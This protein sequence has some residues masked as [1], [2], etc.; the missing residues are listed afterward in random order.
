[1]ED[2]IGRKSELDTLESLFSSRRFEFLLMHGRR[3][4]GKTY[5]LTHFAQKHP[6]NTVFFTADK[7]SQ[8][9]NVHNFCE[10]LDRVLHAGEYLHTLTSW[11]Q[12]YSFLRDR[13]I[14]ERLVIIIDE[15]TYLLNND[16]S[17]DSQ[18]QN[19]IDR[20]LK[21]KNIFLI[22][23]GSEVSTIENLFGDSRKPLYGRKTAELKLKP[24]TYLEARSFF[25][26]YSEEDALKTYAILGG[27]PYYLKLFDS[28]KP[29]KDNIIK[30][31]FSPTGVLYN[32]P[33]A[34]LRMELVEITFY[35]N[36]LLA[37]QAGS[38]TLNEIATKIQSESAKTSKYLHTLINLGFVQ[39]ETPCGEKETRRNSLYMI[40]DNYFAFYFSFIYR[41]RNM[42]NGLIS[43]DAFFQK[44]CTKDKMNHFIG[45]RFE[46]ICTEYLKNQFYLGCM[47]FQA[48]YLGR[49]WGNNPVE[50]RQEEIDI[51]AID[52]ANALFCE[53]KY[54]DQ[55]FDNKELDDLIASSHCVKRKNNYFCIFSRHGVTKSV[56]DRIT[57]DKRFILVTIDDLYQS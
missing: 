12:V 44:M 20:I 30:H 47:P 27:I 28:A 8:Q 57:A 37:I 16:K 34:L 26:S 4:T 2:F 15:F 36:I 50:K 6:E 31:C 52:Q 11:Q 40:S 45:H 24:F 53:C 39:R 3:R 32:E 56:A 13:D 35:Q 33:E 21:Q 46:G 19:A 1:M 43:P 55:P 17:Y 51:L 18:L 10:E 14:S 38:S 48:E 49:W 29:L 25:P 54:T 5:I 42:L 7:S 9:I 41:Y 22:L 23:C